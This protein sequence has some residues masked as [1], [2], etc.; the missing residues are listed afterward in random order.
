MIQLMD[1]DG[2][3]EPTKL[4]VE[5]RITA[6]DTDRDSI[7]GNNCRNDFDFGN[8]MVYGV[9]DPD[10]P[11]VHPDGKR[12]QILYNLTKD[13]VLVYAGTTIR[14]FDGEQAG[15]GYWTRVHLYDIL[16]KPHRSNNW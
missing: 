13:W 6:V 5:N 9:M 7:C 12:C 14:D 11:L 16:K 4:R 2:W 8:D 15:K 3:T 1:T 10:D